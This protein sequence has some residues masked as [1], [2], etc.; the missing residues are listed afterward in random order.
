M[1]FFVAP[2]HETWEI[3]EYL[4]QYGA[5]LRNR[6]AILKYDEIMRGKALP[7]GT[8]VFL[9]TDCLLPCEKE[10][11]ARF[12]RVLSSVR[13]AIKLLNDPGRVLCRYELLKRS[14][15]LERNRFRVFRARE[16]RLC[17]KF[18]VFVRTEQEHIGSLT[19]LL[20]TRQE[21]VRALAMAQIRG[22]RLCDLI[23]V[24]YCDTADSSGVFRLYCASIVGDKIIPQAVV[25]NRNWVTKWAGRLIDEDKAREQLQYVQS[26]P[27]AAWLRD[28]FRLANINYGRID[29][30]L[31]DGVPQVWEINTNPLIVR[32]PGAARAHSE[33]QENLLAP[34]RN[35]FLQQFAAALEEIDSPADPNLIR[36]DIS[37]SE[38]RDLRAEERSRWRL[39]ITTATRAIS[40]PRLVAAWFLRRFR[41]RKKRILEGDVR[42]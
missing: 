1:I 24:E 7:I 3:E 2:A 31:A 26:N 29:Y 5:H 10:I 21:L 35:R 8:Y 27:H 4:L 36:L 23:I 15:A 38:R 34:M 16:F 17:Q 12:C 25:H 37:Q 40:Q 20:Y 33:R 39:M 13:P 14:F 28:T 9:S 19:G 6:V 18:P 32:R 41:A 30:G 22:Y 42:V 11:A